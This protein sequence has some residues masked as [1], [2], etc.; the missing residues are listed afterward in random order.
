MVKFQVPDFVHEEPDGK[1]RINGKNVQGSSGHLNP[2]TESRAILLV[3]IAD[4]KQ[5]AN[6]KVPASEP[7]PLRRPQDSKRPPSPQDDA[8]DMVDDQLAG[9]AKHE[10][11]PDAELTRGPL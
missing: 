7:A 6:G 2:P 10:I 5:Q 11:F 9:D 4:G 8:E 1:Q 3:V